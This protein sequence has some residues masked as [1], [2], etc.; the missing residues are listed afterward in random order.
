MTQ[1]FSTSSDPD[2][3]LWQGNDQ[4][5]F[6]NKATDAIRRYCGWHLWPV[7]PVYSFRAWFGAEGLV[8]LPSTHV[9]GVSSVTVGTLTDQP[10]SLVA[11]EDYYWDAPRPWL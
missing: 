9:T 11:D 7:V 8:T 2:W 1:P 3:A 4:S 6:L 5:F 10:T